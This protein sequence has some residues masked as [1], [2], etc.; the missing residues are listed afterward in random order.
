LLRR[1]AGLPD[2]TRPSD[3]LAAA[4]AKGGSPSRGG[5]KGGGLKGGGAPKTGVRRTLLTRH[6]DGG[7]L[8]LEMQAR[9]QGHKPAY[10]ELPSPIY[11]GN[12]VVHSNLALSNSKGSFALLLPPNTVHPSHQAV[13]KPGISNNLVLRLQLQEPSCGALEPLLALERGAAASGAAAADA[14]R[15]VGAAADAGELGAD[16]AKT[17]AGAVAG[18]S[19]AKDAAGARRAAALEPEDGDGHGSDGSG[20]ARPGRRSPEKPRR[21]AGCL[22]LRAEGHQHAD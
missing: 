5:K 4:A 10:V 7:E 9:G 6:A 2:S 14:T 12:G 19:A 1:L 3:L 16:D 11:G 17:V 21:V 8:R 20:G 15:P 18:G 13:T 22:C